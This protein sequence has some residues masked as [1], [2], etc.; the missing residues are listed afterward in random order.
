MKRELKYLQQD[1][2]KFEAERPRYVNRPPQLRMFEA[3]LKKL[4]DRII[5][6]NC[7]MLAIQG[8][9]MDETMQGRSM[10]LMRYVITWLLRLVAPHRNFPVQGLR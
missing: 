8:V 4:K 2:E 10:Q 5:Q 6:T 9:M 7:S 3:A 1:L